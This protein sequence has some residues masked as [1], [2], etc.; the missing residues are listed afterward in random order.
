MSATPSALETTLYREG[1]DLDQVL[2]AL[3]AQYPGQ[4]RITDVAYGRSGGMMGFFAKR[5]VAVHYTLTNLAAA[6]SAPPTLSAEPLDELLRAADAAESREVP[7]PR[8]PADRPVSPGS[9]RLAAA[10]VE[11]GRAPAG[12]DGLDDETTNVEFARMLLEMASQKAAERRTPPPAPTSLVTPTPTPQIQAPLAP[13]RPAAGRTRS[14]RPLRSP[15]PARC[16]R[17]RL[18]PQ[19]RS[20]PRP[21]R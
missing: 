19:L 15:R 20:P 21:R 13:T 6:P 5:R 4:V 11:S 8:A 18:C 16:R 14:D 10:I 3:D 17:Y 2:A 1:D 12:V 7:P 9:A